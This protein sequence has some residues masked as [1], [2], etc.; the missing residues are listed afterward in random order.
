MKIKE[1]KN[2]HPIIY[3]RVL[4]LKDKDVTDEDNLASS[5]SFDDTKER[6]NIWDKVNSGNFQPFYDF[7]NK[8]NPDLKSSNK[9]VHCKSSEEWDFICKKNNIKFTEQFKEISDSKGECNCIYI[10][11]KTYLSLGYAKLKYKD[12]IITF[13]DWC[14]FNNYNNPFKESNNKPKPK[15]KIGD[16]VN[17]NEKGWQFTKEGINDDFSIG[18][19]KSA[20]QNDVKIIDIIYS[21]TNKVFWYQFNNKYNYYT[22]DALEEIRYKETK[23]K[24]IESELDKWLRETKALNLSLENLQTHI[25]TNAFRINNHYDLIYEKLKGKYSY[26]KAKILYEE[27]NN[28]KVPEKT[29]SIILDPVTKKRIYKTNIEPITLG[30]ILG[31][32]TSKNNTV[33]NVQ[34]A[35]IKLKKRTKRR[36]LN[37]N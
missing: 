28:C 21:D 30:E 29:E 11:N 3:N 2:R 4:E 5:F 22:E 6:F 8:P 9:I 12:Q 13:E 26:D 36:K 35:D 25:N 17:T 15:F 27:W 24:P 32:D 16:I 23:E 1:L 18:F 20:V 37:N 10:E 33:N 19:I 31:E 14:E 7:H 34:F